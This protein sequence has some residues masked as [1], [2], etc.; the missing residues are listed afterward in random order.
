MDERANAHGVKRVQFDGGWVSAATRS[1]ARILQETRPA[2]KPAA[3]AQPEA[4]EAAQRVAALRERHG[5]QLRAVAEAEERLEEEEAAAAAAAATEE[6][7]ELAEGAGAVG[8]GEQEELAQLQAKAQ[9]M[10]ALMAGLQ[11]TLDGGAE[12]RVTLT[13]PLPCVTLASPSPCPSLCVAN[14]PL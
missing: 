10:M 11:Q 6:G 13:L 8:A 9:E 7:E 1:G 14:P 5:A 3:A 4:P 12:V 2:P